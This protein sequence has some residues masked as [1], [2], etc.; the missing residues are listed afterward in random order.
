MVHQYKGLVDVIY[1]VQS[2]LGHMNFWMEQR[3]LNAFYQ[4]QICF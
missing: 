3:E 1:K 2:I 4:A